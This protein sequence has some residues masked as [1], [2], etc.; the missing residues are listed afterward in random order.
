MNIKET[1]NSL[2]IYWKAILYKNFQ[3]RNESNSVFDVYV[4]DLNEIISTVNLEMLTQSVIAEIVN[5]NRLTLSL[6]GNTTDDN[7]E[8]GDFMWRRIINSLESIKRLPLKT[9]H[10]SIDHDDMDLTPIAE[11]KTLENCLIIKNGNLDLRF[12]KKKMPRLKHL[13]LCAKSIENAGALI[14][15]IPAL[16]DFFI[17][18]KEP[19]DFSFLKHLDLKKI[20]LVKAEAGSFQDFTFGDSPFYDRVVAS[21]KMEFDLDNLVPL[22]RLE[23]LSVTGFIIKNPNSFLELTGLKKLKLNHTKISGTEYFSNLINLK[24]INLYNNSITNLSFLKNLTDLEEIDL[25]KNNIESNQLKHLNAVEENLRT[26]I[27]AEN[28]LTDISALSNLKKLKKLDLSSNFIED[29]KPLSALQKLR[30]LNL[31]NNPTLKSIS[32]IS[33][34][35]LEEIKIDIDGNLNI[36]DLGKNQAKIKK[37]VFD[38]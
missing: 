30:D 26:L 15:M 4:E 25:S 3:Q 22:Q 38:A 23:E 17:E 14:S 12:F 21:E 11:C 7:D 36:K 9:L 27:L 19:L 8:N 28:H 20:E 37:S 18:V 1:W 31:R 34:L 2:N 5:H 13:S 35:N 32:S 10:I 16:K 33:K 6:K 24:K 29:T